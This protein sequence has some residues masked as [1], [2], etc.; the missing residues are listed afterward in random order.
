MQAVV[1][2]VL[3]HRFLKPSSNAGK[4]KKNGLVYWITY[5]FIV[6]HSEVITDP[7]LFDFD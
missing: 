1:D 6:I 4:K 3:K 5:P 7:H 2:F